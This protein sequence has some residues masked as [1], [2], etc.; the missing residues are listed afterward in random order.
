MLSMSS[1]LSLSPACRDII[2]YQV[3]NCTCKTQWQSEHG[4][5]ACDEQQSE[6]SGCIQG[7]HIY[8]STLW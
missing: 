1:S 8:I 5:H 3:R 4:S 6:S 7:R 2:S